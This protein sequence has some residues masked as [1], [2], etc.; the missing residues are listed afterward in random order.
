MG[1]VDMSIDAEFSPEAAPAVPTDN[2]VEFNSKSDV[3]G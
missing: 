1:N 3:V 2:V